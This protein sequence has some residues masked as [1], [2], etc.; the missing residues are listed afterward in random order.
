MLLG[1]RW[2]SSDPKYSGIFS[3]DERGTETGFQAER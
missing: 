1:F 2:A 3:N